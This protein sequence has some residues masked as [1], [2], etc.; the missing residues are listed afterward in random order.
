MLLLVV[1][2]VFRLV[3]SRPSC[4]CRRDRDAAKILPEPYLIATISIDNIGW[5]RFA[6]AS[7]V[8]A[9]E[10]LVDRRC[11]KITVDPEDRRTVKFAHD[12]EDRNAEIRYH[13]D[14]NHYFDSVR[15]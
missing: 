13:D 3:R 9:H 7:F 10:F 11:D 2:S 14:V 4:R 8:C 1:V 12:P 5:V 15:E 6:L